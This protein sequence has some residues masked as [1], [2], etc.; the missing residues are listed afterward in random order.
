MMSL[1]TV[2]DEA[3]QKMMIYFYDLWLEGEPI[4]QA[5]INAQLKLRLEYPSPHDW[6][7]FVLIGI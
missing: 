2:S 6:G 1:W 7:A 3:T 4:R 5:F